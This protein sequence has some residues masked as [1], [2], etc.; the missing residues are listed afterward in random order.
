LFWELYQTGAMYR[1][2]HTATEAAA[3]SRDSERRSKDVENEVRKLTA[4]MNALTIGCQ[5]MWE[6]L[7]EH[8]PVTADDLKAKTR[9]IDLRDGV[10]DGRISPQVRSCPACDRPMS[11]HRGQCMYCGQRTES[12]TA[13]G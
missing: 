1:A 11:A 7:S 5:A 4:R 12:G 9:E 6:L 10:E 13:F 8:T 2:H 3:R